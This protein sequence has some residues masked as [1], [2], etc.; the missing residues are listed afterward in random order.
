MAI[1]QSASQERAIALRVHKPPVR[2][3]SAALGWRLKLC[4]EQ[5]GFEVLVFAKRNSGPFRLAMLALRGGLNPCSIF[6]IFARCHKGMDRFGQASV[7]T[8]PMIFRLEHSLGVDKSQAVLPPLL[9]CFGKASSPREM[10]FL[11]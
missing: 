4:W 11:R 6:C 5:R 2:Q 10:S 7:T 9:L 8:L 3:R 1:C